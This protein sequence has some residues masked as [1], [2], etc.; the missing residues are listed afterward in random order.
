MLLV[1]PSSKPETGSLKLK[2]Q[3][4]ESIKSNQNCLLPKLIIQRDVSFWKH[5]VISIILS[6]GNLAKETFKGKGVLL[7]LF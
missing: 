7:L 6:K 4:N 5:A 1:L 3:K 2:L